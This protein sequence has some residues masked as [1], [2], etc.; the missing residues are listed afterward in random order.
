MKETMLYQAPGALD[1]AALYVLDKSGTM[2]R[3]PIKGNAEIG[4]DVP[5]S[6]ADIRI[7]SAIVS[8]RHGE[9]TCLPDG[10]CYR[11]LD[12]MNGTY[13]N[14][15]LHGKK[16]ERAAC[17]LQSGDVL[18]VDQ[19]NLNYTDSD[20]VLM[21]FLLGDDEKEW[22]EMDLAEVEGDILIGR[23]TRGKDGVRL[24]GGGVS[25]RHATFRK[26]LKGWSVVDH[27]STNGVFVNNR[28]IEEAVPLRMMDSVRIADV[29]FLFL[30]NRL[31]YNAA[32]SA[33][34]R[35]AIAIRER[36]VRQMFKKKV[37]LSDIY[38]T[39]DPGE[40]VLIL[41]GSGA[42]KTT[43]LN[44]VMGYEKADGT[45]LHGED[46]IYKDYSRMKYKI[47]FVPQQDL[48]RGEDTVIATLDNAA[49]MKMPMSATAEERAARIEEVLELLG[50][51]R[52]RNS[53]VKK[54]SG[55]QKK[56]LSIAIEFIADP[57]LFFL[58]EPDSGLDGIMAMSLMSNLRV[59][60]DEGKIVMVIT[61][62]PDRVA[63]LFDKVLVLAKSAK[64]NTGR[65][66]FFGGIA[67]AKAFFETD[68]LEGIVRRINR[69]DEG[70]D[71][72]SDHYIE[73]YEEIMKG[74]AGNGNDQA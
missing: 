16:G 49:G 50:L 69:P 13:V 7:Q 67:E 53:L 73:R 72:L 41:G 56:R 46:D 23:E 64:T 25:R 51:Q 11:D 30:G 59:I 36:S 57:S 12:S 21:L 10:Y 31:L 48:I 43:F 18:R 33:E 14:G 22:R 68:T 39:V 38:L 9:I 35:L 44:A 71:G 24:T 19:P 60:A 29:T 6:G 65:L 2:T 28:R 26:G 17:V 54:L 1:A 3:H 15:V 47:G 66:A 52:E 58:D 4:R 45:I 34:N 32:Q 63:A 40:M 8:R 27:N 5:G 74:D 55:G 37:L 70:G 62:A 20:A 61:H 42:G